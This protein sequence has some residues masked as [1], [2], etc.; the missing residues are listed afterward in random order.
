MSYDII[1]TFSAKAINDN[2]QQF[3]PVQIYKDRIV[4]SKLLKI[5]IR[6]EIR[7]TSIR[8]I[9]TK[10]SVKAFLDYRI[11]L[12]IGKIRKTV[13]RSVRAYVS[14]LNNFEKIRIHTS[15]T[16]TPIPVSA[17]GNFNIGKFS[18]PKGL[19]LALKSI[20][21]DMDFVIPLPK[22]EYVLNL[23]QPKLRRLKLL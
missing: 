12:R 13:T 21:A 16:L 10:T 7:S 11:R 23:K 4:K 17:F 5:T 20:P 15:G 6:L 19:T 18:F 14:N 2:I 22:S 3:F 1:F 8:F 9:K